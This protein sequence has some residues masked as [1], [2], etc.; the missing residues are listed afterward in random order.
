MTDEI[1]N[2]TYEQLRLGG[3]CKWLSN[4]PNA[5]FET[6][7]RLMYKSIHCKD[8][9]KIELPSALIRIK[10]SEIVSSPETRTVKSLEQ[11]KNSMPRTHGRKAPHQNGID[12]PIVIVEL[13]GVERL[14]D[15]SNRINY[16][17]SKGELDKVLKVNYHRV[18]RKE[19]E[20]RPG[21]STDTPTSRSPQSAQRSRSSPAR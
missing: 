18:I 17:V 7:C 3:H 2:N 11:V 19:A 8:P 9:G 20:F 21:A 16:W 6:L 1:L 12:N 4:H 14:I 5:G 13:D 10:E 15:G